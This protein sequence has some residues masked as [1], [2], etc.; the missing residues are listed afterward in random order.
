[1]KKNS[2]DFKQT[3]EM[4]NET[5]QRKQRIGCDYGNLRQ[6]ELESGRGK[7]NGQVERKFRNRLETTTGELQRRRD[8]A[9]NRTGKK[10]VAKKTEIKGRKWKP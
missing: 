4:H 1:M 7:E 2:V 6:R 3:N 9:E 5:R 8:V 10:G